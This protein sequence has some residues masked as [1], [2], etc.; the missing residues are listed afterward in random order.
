MVLTRGNRN[1]CWFWT[2][3]S[4]SCNRNISSHC[5]DIKV[6]TQH[7]RG[8]SSERNKS[9]QLHV[10]SD[11][12]IDDFSVAFILLLSLLWLQF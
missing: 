5:C 9:S 7:R 4:V 6:S 8:K 12:R 2:V 11:R 1:G 3:R 10:G